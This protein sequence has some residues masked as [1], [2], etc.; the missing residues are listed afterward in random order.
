M[1]GD[2]MRKYRNDDII[3]QKKRL[4][5]LYF[6]FFLA[7]V[8][9]RLFITLIRPYEIDMT[10][11]VTWSHYLASYGPN[12]FYNGSGYHVV[13][14]PFFIY[15][16]WFTGELAQAFS[17]STAA[18]AYIIKFW[19]VLF[20]LL[21]SF[22]IIKL[23]EKH[24][25][26]KEGYLAAL[27][28][29]VNPGVFMNSS[30]WGQ[31]DSVPAAMLLGVLLLFE[32]KKPNLGAL[33]FLVAV[34]TKPQ[35]GLLL[36][37]VLYLYF[38]DLRLDK[39][40]IRRISTGLLAGIIVYLVIV[41]PFYSPTEKAG[42]MPRFLDPFYWLFDL[43]FRSIQ[44]Y[45]YATANAF[46][47]WTL[48]GGQ[49]QP[50]TMPFLGLSYLWWGNILLAA[51]IIYAF[52]CILKSRASFHSVS[53]FSFLVL[54]TSF[55][56]MTR[57][58]ERYLLPAIIFITVCCMFE[59]RHL[60]VAMTLSICVFFNQ[61]YIYIISF[62]NTYWVDRWDP[63]SLIIAGFTLAVYCVSVFNGYRLFIKR[64]T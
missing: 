41:L 9:F 27:L 59:K 36:P 46:N 21:G 16:L 35:S 30:V 57:M 34:L 40:Y 47:F 50:D 42:S 17:L 10:G 28:Y 48:A 56:F 62:D 3:S 14:A 22:L 2:K 63:A 60:L 61:L 12:R 37:V 20:E 53:Y 29:F 11:Y 32:Y 7:A 19:S 33:L 64:N 13:Y 6:P 55:M 43:Y 24:N 38:R 31:F 49:I 1:L 23:A 4:Y 52:V 26:L 51:G 15:F 5:N 58:H 54:F 25:R 18:T 8:V 45:P 39:H 44:D